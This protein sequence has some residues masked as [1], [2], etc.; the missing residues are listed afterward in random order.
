MIFRLT[1]RL[2]YK[3]IQT[4][5]KESLLSHQKFFVHSNDEIVLF[6]KFSHKQK[7]MNLELEMEK[8]MVSVQ[9]LICHIVTNAVIGFCA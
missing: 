7:I 4:I 9:F 2:R 1:N 5:K 8:R 6:E 3:L